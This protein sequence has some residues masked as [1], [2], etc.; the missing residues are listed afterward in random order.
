CPRCCV[1]NPVAIP[2]PPLPNGSNSSTGSWARQ[3]PASTRGP[4]SEWSGSFWRGYCSTRAATRPRPPSC[5]AS[6]VAAC[7]T[8]SV[9]SDCRPTNS[10]TRIPD[11]EACLAY[12]HCIVSRRSPRMQ[13]NIDWLKK[14]HAN[15][16]QD[17]ADLVAI[18]SVSTDGEHQKQI[19]DSAAL[20]AQHMKK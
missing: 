10:V 20:T 18:K 3:P 6:P 11:A 19:D 14:H 4:W 1:S 13:A 5:S 12:I 7:G 2:L 15:L 17:L 9:P 8:S 16:V